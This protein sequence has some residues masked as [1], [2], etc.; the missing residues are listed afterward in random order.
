MRV[1]T[2]AF[3]AAE[4]GRQMHPQ[5]A[6]GKRDGGDINFKVP[7]HGERERSLSELLP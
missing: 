1:V 7:W 2:P 6:G 4:A 5:S 3:F